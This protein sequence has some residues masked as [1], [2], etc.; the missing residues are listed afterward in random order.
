MSHDYSE[1]DGDEF[2][3]Q[4]QYAIEKNREARANLRKMVE[5]TKLMREDARRMRDTARAMR[6]H[7]KC[8]LNRSA[9]HKSYS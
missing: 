2:L 1:R 3:Q 6:E 8:L 4:I 7:N 5:E 9:P